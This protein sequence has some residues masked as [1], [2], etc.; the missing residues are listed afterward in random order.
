MGGRAPLLVR[1]PHALTSTLGL[2]RGLGLAAP[3]GPQP[4]CPALPVGVAHVLSA[5]PTRSS[6]LPPSSSV[7]G[8]GDCLPPSALGPGAGHRGPFVLPSR[9]CACPAASLLP[10]PSQ[11]AEP[12]ELPG[13][14]PGVSRR[15]QRAMVDASVPVYP[16]ARDTHLLCVV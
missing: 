9:P 8:R 10:A 7:P 3:R 5:Q 1:R 13:N 2:G 4:S 15:P 16:C 14:K 6:F 12:Q 11:A